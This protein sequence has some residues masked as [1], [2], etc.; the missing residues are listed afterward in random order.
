VRTI[1]DSFLDEL[2][3]RSDIYDVVSGYVRLTKRS[4]ANV[5]GLCPF[6]NEKT[7]SFTVNTE[8]QFYHCFGC[9][10]GGGVINF[11][12][13]IENV[14]FIDAV[15]ILAKRANMTVPTTDADNELTEK[16]QRILNLN[17][18]AA[19]YFHELL[20][21]P[22]SQPARDYLVKRGIGKAMVKRFGIGFA[23]ESWNLL[24]EAMTRKGYKTEEL[25]EAGLANPS[26][27]KSGEAAGGIYDVFRNR[28]MFPVIDTRGNVI[29]FSGRILDAG[30]PK[31]LN[32]RDTLVYNKRR[33]LF[34]LNLAKKTKSD[35]LIL[36]EGNID[37]VALHQAGF[38]NTVAS[39]GTAL[40]PEQAQLISRH[41]SKVVLAYD[42]DEGGRKAVL[43]A[44]PIL[45]KT[46]MHVTVIDLGASGDPDDYIKKHGPEA[47]ELLVERGDD[48][49]EY[50][51]LNIKNN[52]DLT[53]DSGRLSYLGSATDLLSSLTSAPQREVYGSRVAN[54]ADISI[55]A[56]K[57]EVN[58]K[59]R[60]RET[61]QKKEFEKR[62]TRSA[63]RNQPQDKS[64]RYE[65]EYSAIAEEGVIRLIIK[66]PSLMSVLSEKQ[67]SETEFTSDFLRKI[68]LKIS[69]RIADNKNTDPALLMADLESFETSHLT[70]ILQKPEAMQSIDIALSEYIEKI[71]I[72]KFKDRQRDE[73][74]LLEYMAQKRLLREEKK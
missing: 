27:S 32:S 63:G 35:T 21:S 31:Y 70:N 65:N 60:N 51:L 26:K 40:T 52:H 14:P 6:H 66:D 58:K 73:S 4:G 3:S 57:T 48:H 23:P 62:V 1:P 61:K 24:T 74:A 46:G 69:K 7:P 19:R 42:P 55:D 22:L 12:K 20:K 37:V 30:E 29:G 8:K 2:V 44:I 17:R 25:I 59:L 18:D 43:R 33:S 53:T 34:A 36:V 38:D 28:L 50:Q 41:V 64:L 71:R 13:E 9:Q 10:K 47:F 45:E 15:E 67:F 49:I 16:R 68:Y 39:L 72:E 5:F 54:I 11:I 56:V